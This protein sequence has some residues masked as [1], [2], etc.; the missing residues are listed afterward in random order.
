MYEIEQLWSSDGIYPARMMR[1]M[2]EC[3]PEAWD[4]MEPVCAVNYYLFREESYDVSKAAT[5]FRHV[6]TLDGIHVMEN[7]RAYDRAFLVPRLEVVEDVDT[8]FQQVRSPGYDPKAVALTEVQPRIPLPEASTTDLGT[9]TLTQRSAN[10]VTVQVDAVERCLLVVSE[11]YYPGWQAYIDAEEAEV[12]PVYHAFR[13]V[14]IPEGKHTV[15]FRMEPESFYIGLT[16]S[17]VALGAGLVIASWVLWR[18][19]RPATTG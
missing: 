7:M 17:S 13:G 3:Y 16:I 9:A 12:L 6:V 15:T 5:R 19:H 4:S 14:I 8:L 11:A 10:A 1:F 18:G 2:D